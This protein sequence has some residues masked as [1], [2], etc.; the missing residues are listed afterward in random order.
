MTLNIFELSYDSFDLRHSK[1]FRMTIE[2]QFMVL[3]IK[4]SSEF[5]GHPNANL[6]EV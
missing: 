3:R 1:L 4:L 5:E 6:L 2:Y